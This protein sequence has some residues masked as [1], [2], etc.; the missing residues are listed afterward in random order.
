RRRAASEWLPGSLLAR[1]LRRGRRV[2]GEQLL[3]ALTIAPGT[4]AVAGG[5]L[6]AG[7]QVQQFR[8]A[9]ADGFAPLHEGAGAHVVAVGVL[10]L[11]DQLQQ[12]RIL[13][14][15]VQAVAQIGLGPL[16]PAGLPGAAAGVVVGLV[17]VAVEGI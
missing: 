12:G 4:A 11:G 2:V 15:Q 3:Q 9:G 17:L 16:R 10:D 7:R 14:R 13:W 6:D 5:L 8:G 1:L